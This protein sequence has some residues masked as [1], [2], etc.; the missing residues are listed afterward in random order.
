[1]KSVLT[2]IHLLALTA[3]VMAYSGGPPDGKTGAPGEGTCVDCHTSYPLNS[4]NGTFSISAPSAYEPGQTYPIT[5]V[6][7][8]P[9]QLR[10]GFELTPLSAGVITVTDPANTQ[11]SI[12]GDNTYIKHTSAG[13]F[14]GT[15]D[16]PVSWTF[17]WTAP[18]D[19]LP[20]TITLYA[21]GNAANGNFFNTF[22]YIYTT[23]A[24]INLA[25]DIKDF[26]DGALPALLTL[27]SYPNPFN[28]V[29]NISYKVPHDGHVNLSIYDVQGRMIT[30]LEDGY[31]S[32]GSFI[33]SWDG[34][35]NQGRDVVSGIYFAR[36]SIDDHSTAS[37]LV[38]L[39]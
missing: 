21:A 11:I 36:L 34:H 23:S 2:A 31:R 1:M 33:T 10:W 17:D 9:G 28:A 27:E 39:K 6:I 5:V 16:G 14:N 3:A 24:T 32:A 30:E 4:G 35:D 38:L 37:R 13:T 8:D 12:T 25:T 7:S 20:E 26:N 18:S 29:A 22:D 15:E 19:N